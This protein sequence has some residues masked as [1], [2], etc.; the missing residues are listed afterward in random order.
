MQNKPPKWNEQ[1]QAYCLNFH[2]RVKLASV[3]NFQLVAEDNKDHIILQFGK[4]SAVT[5]TNTGADT[6][7]NTST[8][9]NTNIQ[10]IYLAPACGGGQQGSRHPLVQLI[11]RKG[12]QGHLHD[13][14]SV[15][16]VGDAGVCHL[17]DQLRQ[18]VGV[19]MN[20]RKRKL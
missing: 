16:N 17:L 13:G 14:L 1:M 5:R 12:G 10:V 9:T 18:Q 8:N 6:S 2:G 20:A 7:T 15:P 19:R 3:K 4:V 11:L